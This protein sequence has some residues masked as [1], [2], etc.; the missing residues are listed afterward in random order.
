MDKFG[1]KL[2]NDKA[3]KCLKTFLDEYNLSDLWRILYPDRNGFTWHR[4][5]SRKYCSRLDYVFVSETLTQL[6]KDMTVNP[7]FRSD[8]A[9]VEVLLVNQHS[10]RAK[11]Y[12]KFNTSL[13]RDKDYVDSINQLN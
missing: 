5:S 7:E 2:N 1:S 13:L 10:I 8:H 3:A 6:V 9:I 4:A 11:G 12:W